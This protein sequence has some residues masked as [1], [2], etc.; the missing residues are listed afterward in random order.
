MKI[1]DLKKGDGFI[2]TQ[3][4][5]KVK[6]VMEREATFLDVPSPLGSSSQ[7]VYFWHGRRGNKVEQF[8]CTKGC[9]ALFGFKLDKGE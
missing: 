6:W 2:Q 9:E 5:F 1:Q 8:S 3:G 7:R 4:P